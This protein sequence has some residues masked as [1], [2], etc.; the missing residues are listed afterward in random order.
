AFALSIPAGA[1]PFRP[2][3]DA[4]VLEHLPANALSASAWIPAPSDPRA[5]AAVAQLYIER[6][7]RDGDPRFLGYA[8]GV[9]RTWW[10][11]PE[12]PAPVLLL[13]ATLLQA[14]HHFP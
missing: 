10:S 5:A 13:R 9:L 12:P 11:D 3:D 8:E 14:R 4:Q 7:R 1:A 6:S 2:T